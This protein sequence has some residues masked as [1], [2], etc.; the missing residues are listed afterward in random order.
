[1]TIGKYTPLE[2]P[3]TIQYRTKTQQRPATKKDGALIKAVYD[4][5]VACQDFSPHTLQQL[6][7]AIHGRCVCSRRY[8]PGADPLGRT[9]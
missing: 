9:A 6:L 7:T 5:F 1:M 4:Y 3:R 2:S 8:R